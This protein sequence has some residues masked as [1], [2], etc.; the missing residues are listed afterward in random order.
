MIKNYQQLVDECPHPK[1]KDI[2]SSQ[3]EG[4]KGAGGKC[5]VCGHIL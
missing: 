5:V 4:E 2:D 1:R 3:Y